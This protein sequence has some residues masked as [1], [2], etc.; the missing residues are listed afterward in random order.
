MKDNADFLFSLLFLKKRDE[1][2]GNQELE[3]SRLG[4]ERVQETEKW[5]TGEHQLITWSLC[6]C[7]RGVLPPVHSFSRL[8]TKQ[9]VREKS[10][11]FM[12]AS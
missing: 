5:N 4:A 9:A 12:M 10:D 7:C 1:K 6:W 11:G 2:K 8:S 3:A